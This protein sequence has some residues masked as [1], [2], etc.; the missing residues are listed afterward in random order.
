MYVIYCVFCTEYEL[1]CSFDT[2]IRVLPNVW[3]VITGT[4]RW[5]PDEHHSVTYHCVLPWRVRSVT[6]LRSFP[7]SRRPGDL[8]LY[9]SGVLRVGDPVLYFIYC[10]F[11][12][13]YD[14]FI[15]G[16]PNVWLVITG[17]GRWPPDVHHSVTYHCVLPRRVRSVTS[18][19]SF[20]ASRR[21]G[22]RSL[23]ISGVLLVGDPVL[24][25]IYCHF[26]TKYELICSFN[27]LYTVLRWSG[28]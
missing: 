26:C 25:L 7:A 21:P 12:T 14:T 4:G 23:C 24:Y 3:H 2:F 5:P 18:L 13:K 19:R 17:T 16:P 10:L 20:P 11:C 15:R 1:I 6:S 27:T 28:D 9:I 22:E 8:P